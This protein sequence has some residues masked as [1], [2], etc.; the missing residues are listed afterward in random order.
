MPGP[1]ASPIFLVAA[2]RDREGAGSPRPRLAHRASCLRPRRPIT[3]KAP[4]PWWP[5]PLLVGHL[6]VSPD[7]RK[8]RIGPWIFLSNIA[9]VPESIALVFSRMVKNRRPTF[10]IGSP[11]GLGDDMARQPKHVRRS[12]GRTA[13]RD[14]REPAAPDLCRL[15]SLGRSLN[16]AAASMRKRGRAGIR[17]NGPPSSPR[18]YAQLGRDG[19]HGSVDSEIGGSQPLLI[20]PKLGHEVA[21]ARRLAPAVRTRPPSVAFARARQPSPMSAIAARPRRLAPEVHP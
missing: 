2:V 20:P 15:L 14:E 10:G 13:T 18:F 5:R 19:G 9:F 11:A 4:E 7:D 16:G 17:S 3:H 21:C 1:C 12:R 8:L 6:H